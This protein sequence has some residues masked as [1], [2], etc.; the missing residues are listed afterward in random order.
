MMVEQRARSAEEKAA[1]KA[2]KE[3]KKNPKK[4]KPGRPKASKNQDKTQ[5]TLTP[6]L[7]QI[8]RMVQKLLHLIGGVIRIEHMVMDGKF[9]NNNALQMV[10]QCGQ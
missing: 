2:K 5:V 6:E 9:G 7:L 10:R 4:G 8:Q 3:V 1:T